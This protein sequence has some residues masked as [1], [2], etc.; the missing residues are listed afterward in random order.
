[1]NCIKFI[2]KNKILD[3]TIN[4]LLTLKTCYQ[5]M[6]PIINNKIKLISLV[7]FIIII[8]QK[9]N[10]ND[11]NQ[12]I[13]NNI[14]KFLDD[15]IIDI[16]SFHNIIPKIVKNHYYNNIR[17]PRL[18]KWRDNLKIG[19]YC[20]SIDEESSITA[21]GYNA[22]WF[23]A[24][25]I[26]IRNDEVEVKY[27][28]WKDRYNRWIDKNDTKNIL[29]HMTVKS[30]W[31]QKLRKNSYVEIQTLHTKEFWNGSEKEYT[32][33]NK[34]KVIH[35]ERSIKYKNQ[36]ILENKIKE[37]ICQLENGTLKIFT[38]LYDPTLVEFGTHNWL[39]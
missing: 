13:S 26:K 16:L 23:E 21:I 6:N 30:N 7:N 34:A 4:K 17:I 35:V 24:K 8:D 39:K 36:E 37:I 31:R 33:W 1:M 14:Y 9:L 19:D 10:F 29:P 12:K 5:K 27:L 28:G 11:I 38:D 2:N 20:D 3:D 15:Y 25:I 32:K 22:R 18:N